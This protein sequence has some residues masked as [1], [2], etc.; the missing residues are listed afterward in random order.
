[1]LNQIKKYCHNNIKNNFYIQQ[2]SLNQCGQINSF[3]ADD[4]TNDMPQI[5]HVH[6]VEGYVEDTDNRSEHLFLLIPSDSYGGTEDIIVDGAVDQ[7]THKNKK[8][9]HVN[10]AFGTKAELEPILVCYLSE[11][12]YN[13]TYYKKYP[14]H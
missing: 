7:F 10:S 8:D 14:K 6:M 11:S 13:H 2:N 5:S 12:P 9:G 1:M 3:I 4:I